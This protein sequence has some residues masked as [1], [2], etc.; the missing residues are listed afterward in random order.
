MNGLKNVGNTCYMN[1]ALQLLKSVPAFVESSRR[2]QMFVERNDPTMPRAWV[3]HKHPQF[4]NFAQH[5]SH[6]WF[7]CLLDTLDADTAFQGTFE[8]TVTFND[9]GHSNVHEETFV[10][11]SLPM[12][13]QTMAESLHDFFTCVDAVT[14]T[15]DTCSDG[16]K[17]AASK[18]TKILVLPTALVV[19]WKRFSRGGRKIK[20][21]MA[22]PPSMFGKRL[23]AVV[24]HVG[25]RSGSGHYT[26]CVATTDGKCSYISDESV[27][28][29]EEKHFFKAAE[30]GYYMVY[31]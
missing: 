13:G 12:V 8:V 11:I 23:R 7:L 29:I 28:R 6:E 2:F 9:C 26:A 18:T 21:R 5:D 25:E 27:L 1:A 19:H 3:G 22:T 24:N 14:S 10:T 31:A 30:A 20:T 17:R 15:C 4:R 16:R